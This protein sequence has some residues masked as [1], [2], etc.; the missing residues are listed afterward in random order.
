M[1]TL[2]FNAVL[3]FFVVKGNAVFAQ[4]YPRSTNNLIE[5]KTTAY[6]SA[7]VNLRTYPSTSAQIVR[8]IPANTKVEILSS[9]GD[10]YSV[11]YQCYEGQYLVAKYGYVSKSYVY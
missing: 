11:E 9:S 4:D 8:V 10:W 5:P 2:V 3:L 1:K 6:T 7:N